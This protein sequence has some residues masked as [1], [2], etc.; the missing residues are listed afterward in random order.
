MNIKNK[1]SGFILAGFCGGMAEVIWIIF[2]SLFKDLELLSI[3]SAISQTVFFNSFDMQIAPLMGLIVHLCLSVLLAIAFGFTLLPFIQRFSNNF[4][5][6]LASL[7]TLAI[8]WKI[9]FFILLPVWNPDF[10]NL[11]PLHVSLLSKLLFGLSMGIVLTQQKSIPRQ[12]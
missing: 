4:S 6:L 1:T 8:V 3:A 7:I 9:N 2:Y 12:A 5:T 10:I 11:L